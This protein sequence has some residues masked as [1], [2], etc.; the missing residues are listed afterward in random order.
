MANLNLK[1]F[2]KRGNP[3]N[4]NYVGPTGPTPLDSKFVYNLTTGTSSAGQL[5]ITESGTNYVFSFFEND[6]NNFNLDA[7]YDEA[8][9]FL[10]QGSTLFLLGR[11]VGAQQ[12]RGKISSLSQVGNVISVT[13]PKNDYQ[14]Q[15]IISNG[16][17]IYFQT[18]FIDRPGGY[19]KGNIYFEPV[20]T[21]L[22]ENE[23]IFIVQEVESASGNQYVLPHTGVTG[24][25][26]GK[27]RSR[28]YNDNYGET[29]VTEIIFTYSIEDE[30]PGG[31]GQPLIISYPNLVYGVD[32]DPNDYLV[33]GFV[34]TSTL[35]SEAISVNVALNATDEAESV[36]ERKLIIED[37][38]SGTPEKILEV[39]FYGQVIGEDERFK[40]LLDVE[41]FELS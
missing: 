19:F 24:A 17:Q 1:F 23:Q 25:T 36:Y 13:I 41:T 39:D 16:N 40:V 21:G 7:W 22:Y 27:W 29:D 4:F 11:V 8:V 14:G 6:L 28:W 30:L 10:D 32:A 26:A 18:E 34:Y 31:Q 3:L 20:S 38:S 33:N 9:S 12:F 2:N 37:I 5:D 15:S 35:N